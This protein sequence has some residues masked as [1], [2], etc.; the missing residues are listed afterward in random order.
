MLKDCLCFVSWKMKESETP[1]SK[2]NEILS[3]RINH[4]FNHKT[5]SSLKDL[6]S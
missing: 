2:S 3:K 1:D 6:S 5:M 4:S